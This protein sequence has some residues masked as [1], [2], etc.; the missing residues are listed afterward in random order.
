MRGYVKEKNSLDDQDDL[1][2][3]KMLLLC[4]SSLEKLL[5]Q[6]LP[7]VPCAGSSLTAPDKPL[8]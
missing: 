6:S 4:T 1:T 7:Q 5:P 8:S 3:K 2:V